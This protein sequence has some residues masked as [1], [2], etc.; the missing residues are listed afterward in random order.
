MRLGEFVDT[1][2]VQA[3]IFVCWATW[4]LA[5]ARRARLSEMTRYSHCYML[6]QARWASLSETETLAWA[7]WYGLSKNGT[8]SCVCALFGLEGLSLIG[9][10][11]C[12]WWLDTWWA[13][14]WL[15]SRRLLMGEKS[16]VWWLHVSS[17]RWARNCYVPVGYYWARSS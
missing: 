1:I 17:A 15:S 7:N 4:G 6:A 8:E 3:R 12:A 14:N 16:L 2:L 10:L 13:W 5:E 11:G 9:G